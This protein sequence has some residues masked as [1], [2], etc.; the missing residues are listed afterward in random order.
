MG[1]LRADVCSAWLTSDS[2]DELF[3]VFY[4]TVRA[5]PDLLSDG[6]GPFGFDIHKALQI[7]FIVQNLKIDGLIETGTCRGDT[8]E[9]LG[10]AYPHLSV[11]SC[12]IQVDLARF[13]QARTKDFPNVEV[14]LGDSGINIPRLS[15]GIARPLYYLDAHWYDEWPL[16]RELSAI[17]RGIVAIDDFN[18][19]LSGFGWDSYDG[20]TCGPEVLQAI[21]G[22]QYRVFVGNPYGHYPYPCLQT[23]RRSGVGYLV[24]SDDAEK[25]H[26]SDYF[27]CVYNGREEIRPDW[28]ALQQNYTRLFTE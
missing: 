9:Y 18:I 14:M 1:T 27:V 15:S 3:A 4:T 12:E 13:A 21:L 25:F 16:R 28:I 23:R 17:H 24:P 26:E 20:V 5:A 7:D 22:P 10:R 19:G 2:V 6:G 11:R 8:T